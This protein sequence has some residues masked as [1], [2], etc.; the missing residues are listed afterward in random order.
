MNLIDFIL[1]SICAYILI[2][3]TIRTVLYIKRKRERNM[4]KILRK[5]VNE[6]WEVIEIE[7]TLEALQHEVEGNIE[8]VTVTSDC[9]V[10]INE[11]S[12][13]KGHHFNVT[14]GGLPL[15][16]TVLL[17]GTLNDEFC[18]LPNPDVWLKWL[19]KVGEDGRESS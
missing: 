4:I 7:N 16:G 1:Y 2:Y 15:F 8:T 6:P 3:Y 19:N 12:L 5:K 17:V 13:L 18:D 10:V 14:F 9:C 11:E